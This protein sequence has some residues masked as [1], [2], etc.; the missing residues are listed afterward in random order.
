[1]A[2]ATAKN[3][4]DDLLARTTAEAPVRVLDLIDRFADSVTRGEAKDINETTLRET[5][6]NPLFE[7]LGWDPRNRRGVPGQNRDVILEDKIVVDGKTKAPDY[8]FLVDQRRRL[9]VEAKRPSVNIDQDRN[10]A[11]QLRRY[12]WSAG[13]PFGLLTDFE[14][15][16]IYDCRAAPVPTDDSGVGRVAYFRYNEL[17]QHWPLLAGMFS[18]QSVAS[19]EL[20]A[21]AAR[22]K[23]PT[24]AKPIDSAFLDEIREWRTALASVIAQINTGLDVL[25]LNSVVQ[26]LIDRIIF[27][28]IAEARGLEPPEALKHAAESERGVYSELLTLFVR[29]NDRYNSGLFHFFR[30]DEVRGSVDDESP[31]LQVPDEV[32]RQIIGRLYYPVPYEFS[33]LPAD[34]LGRIYEQFL[35]ERISLTDNHEAVVEQKPEVKKAGG[36][37]YT[38]TPIVDYIVETT[39]GPL[40]TGKTPNQV[41]NIRI[42]DPACGSGSFLI[43][44]YQY[45]IDWHTHYYSGGVKLAKDNLE[46]QPDGQLRLKTSERKRVLLNNIFG[47][48]IDPQAVEVTKLSLLLKVIE[49]ERQTELNVGR[50]LPDLDGNVVCGNSLIGLDFSWSFQPTEE[51]RLKFNPFSWTTQWPEI[52]KAGG[53]DAVIGNPPYLNIDDVWGRRD[54]RLTYIKGHYQPVYVDKTDILFYFIKKAVDICKGEIGYIVS[55]SFLEAFKAQNLREWLAGEVRVREILDF[56]EAVVFPKVGINTAIIR[57]TKSKAPKEASF[58]RWTTVSLPPGYTSK[59]LQDS[60]NTEN[61]S[62]ANN[63]LGRASWNFGSKVVET[64]LAKLDAAGTPLGEILHVGQGMQTGRNPAFVLDV[65]DLRYAE[66]N[67][68]GVAYERARNSDIIAYEIRPS[69]IYM[70]F[71]SGAASFANLPDEIRRL[72]EQN[73]DS[74]RER[75]AYKR[76]DCEWWHYTWPLHCQYMD[77][78]RIFCPYRSGTNR[79]A[80]DTE[81]AYLGVTDTTVLFDSTQSED[82]KYILG[83]LNARISEFRFGFLGKL[84][85]GGVLEYYPNTVCQLPIPRREPGDADHD[86]LVL[87][88]ESRMEATTELRSTLIEEERQLLEAVINLRDS[89]IDELVADL[90]GLTKAE[91][92]L[93]GM[94]TE[95][96]A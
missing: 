46:A 74:L 41:S 39:V 66:L 92:A 79:F 87:L 49:G 57:L 29:A 51:E 4:S 26:N 23:E 12:C 84:L 47:V 25:Q 31:T 70:A 61:L 21:I 5:Y 14:E 96:R 75:A 6:L 94:I 55:R 60:S 54:A 78:S 44:A 45:V 11:L 63:Q 90:F 77:R 82:M 48:D 3:P 95:T 24:N 20:D 10:P 16:A 52:F 17:A 18:K 81:G 62:I 35:G 69:R 42:V 50:L 72:I 7:D 80:L 76:G 40:L 33:V 19:G 88:V 71:P 68:E 37:Y 8:T 9:F 36:I 1:M 2:R 65:T 86:Q 64:L 34:M 30:K 58:R 91:R 53:F 73:E 15:F 67:A 32:L 85:G 83:V 89:A 22:T 93:A 43:A 56:R 38:P 59:T 28:R 13:L 27:L